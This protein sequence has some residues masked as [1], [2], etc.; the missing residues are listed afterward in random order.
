MGFFQSVVDIYLHIY[1][2][3]LGSFI[4]DVHFKIYFG[5]G[6]V[7]SFIKKFLK[8]VFLNFQNGK[9]S[10]EIKCFHRPLF[11]YFFTKVMIIRFNFKG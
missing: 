6:H 8:E 11:P 2:W 3:I 9:F 4:N 1:K 5:K 10:L 7:K